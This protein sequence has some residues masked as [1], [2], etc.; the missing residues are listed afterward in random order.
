MNSPEIR[1]PASALAS[2]DTDPEQGR[3]LAARLAGP[4]R[5]TVLSSVGLAGATV[6]LGVLAAEG[7][8]ASSLVEHDEGTLDSRHVPGRPLRWQL[9]VPTSP[10]GLVL[11][12][13]GKGSS[14]SVWFGAL[15]AEAVA[16]RTGLAIAAID[17][18]R[19]YWH[20]RD[21]S[22]AP[23]MLTREFL[24]MLTAR[25]LSTDRI[26]LTGIS[27][28]GYG[29]LRLAAELGPARVWGV[30]TM[31]AAL[32]TRFEDTSRGAFDDEADFARHSVFAHVDALGRVPVRLACGFDDRFYRG[33]RRLARLLP[34]AVTVFDE[35]GHT[36]DYCRSHWGGS[37]AWLAS[38]V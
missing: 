10:R 11:A 35:G 28:G 2:I 5:R 31:C 29:A 19:T 32:R 15:S 13:H 3:R 6:A 1:E 24:P 9:A 7:V 20:R 12:L 33:N 4:T 34:H 14:S 26:G 16:A 30:A 22:D 23:A 17:G 37:M 27:M 36:T 18:R 8:G 38:L 25:G 21:D